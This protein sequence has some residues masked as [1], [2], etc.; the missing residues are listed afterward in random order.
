[1]VPMRWER[2]FGSKLKLVGVITQRSDLPRLWCCKRYNLSAKRDLR[3]PS[4]RRNRPMMMHGIMSRLSRNPVCLV[5]VVAD[6]ETD[7]RLSA[8]SN[9]K[10]H[11]EHSHLSGSTLVNSSFGR[12]KFALPHHS[13]S[14]TSKHGPPGSRRARVKQR[15]HHLLHLSKPESTTAETVE[16]SKPGTVLLDQHEEIIRVSDGNV[17]YLTSKPIPSGKKLRK[18]VVTVV[19]KDQGWSSYKKDHGTYRNSWTWFELSVGSPSEELGEKWRSEVVRNLHA[20]GE[21]KEHTIEIS[22]K[23]LYE[24]AESGD[25]L[26]VWAHAR[27]PGWKHTVKRVTIRYVVE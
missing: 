7:I 18:V 14:S 10:G 5:S 8:P 3:N 9:S 25:V 19:S 26:M 17:L 16:T 23:G 15:V 22:D 6:N 2:P 21:F 20:H 13:G 4:H 12:L 11:K 24:K 27:F 1:M